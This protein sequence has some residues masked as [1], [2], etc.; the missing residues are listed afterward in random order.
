MKRTALPLTV[1][2][3]AITCVACTSTPTPSVDKS[4][5]DQ[6]ATPETVALY[7][8][9]FMLMERG[10]MLGHQDDLV[11]GHAWYGDD[12]RSDV[13]DVTGDYPAI[14][15][16]DLGHLETGADHNLDS[17]YFAD[18][19]RHTQSTQARGGVVTFSWHANNVA[20]NGSTWDNQQDTVVRSML[21]GGVHH[22]TYLQWLD[23]L[24]DFFDSL[25]DPDGQPIPIIFRMFHEHTGAWF[26]WGNEQCTPEEYKELW[27]MTVRYLRDTKK[28]NHL[29]YAYSTSAVADE[30]HFLE[31]YP[32]DEYVD[33]IG[34]DH[35]MMGDDA[36]AKAEYADVLEQNI[37]IITRYA[38]QS[39][40]IPAVTETGH[41]SIRD[42]AYF[43]ETVYPIIKEYPLSWILFWR[44]AWEGDKPDHYYLPYAGHP[45]A[46]DFEAFASQPDILMN[47]DIR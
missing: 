22:A 41:E 2:I 20:T 42:T 12:G 17:V 13:H 4:P 40:K 23:R 19:R 29:L 21:P 24:A 44:N 43:T 33:I 30:A 37:R 9:L 8:R 7:N 38:E 26:W 14:V 15:G 28:T 39:G 10:T 31:R 36:E 34:F 16:F 47:G 18:M 3:G 32:G 1:L 6:T 35:Y 25:R 11:Y 27:T 46:A 45:A 5:I